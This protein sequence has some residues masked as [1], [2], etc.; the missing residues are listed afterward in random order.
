MRNAV[1]RVDDA[2]LDP[3][4]QLADAL[5]DLDAARK[6]SAALAA[7]VD[8]LRADIAEL[9]EAARTAEKGL[10][11]AKSSYAASVAFAADSGAPLTTS[12]AVRLGRL[13]QQDIA[14]E[15]DVKTAALKRLEA[16][17]KT[18]AGD[19]ARAEAEVDAAINAVL[20][21]VAEKLL[22]DARN[23][24]QQIGRYRDLLLPLLLERPTIGDPH[25]SAR[26]A[27]LAD[28][29]DAVMQFCNRHRIV[30]D[31]SAP[32]HFA[33]WRTALRTDP[34]AAAPQELTLGG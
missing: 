25:A 31:P 32:N 27:P 26:Q 13:Q 28:V 17:A 3:R 16:D 7:G 18:Q 30:G 24:E 21:P 6:R 1:T 22:H 11:E 9:R 29:R 4:Q 34:M 2:P 14:D 12:D 10:E 8:H 19:V 20:E 5:A 23:V 33:E 15:L